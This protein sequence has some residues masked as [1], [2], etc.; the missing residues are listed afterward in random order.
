MDRVNRSWALAKESLAVLRGNPALAI[1]PVLS[2]I[3]TLIVSAPFV[4]ILAMAYMHVD[5]THQQPSGPLYYGVTAAMYFANYFVM[6]F[7]NSALV[8]CAN[9]NL[10]GRPTTVG[11]GIN[12]AVKRLTQILGWALISSTVGMILKIVGERS[13]LIGG[14]VTALVGLVWNIAVYFVVP[15][16]VLERVGP[17]EA[18]KSSTGM[19]KRTWG[20]RVIMGIGLG[21][22][23]ALI[24]LLVV[25]PFLV[26]IA[27]MVMELYALGIILFIATVVFLLILSVAGSALTTI[28][29]TAL[30]QYCKTGTTPVGFSPTSLQGAFATKPESKFF[31]L[32]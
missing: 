24:G 4:A 16:L 17:I 26:G 32:K 14:I 13:G 29:Q 15:F 30:Y 23:M 10:Q 12:A 25:I 28:Y 8:A 5:K 21:T 18:I 1:F 6:I 20:E 9:E 3:A 2:G 7:F 22:A 27:M 11:F 19:I 31:R